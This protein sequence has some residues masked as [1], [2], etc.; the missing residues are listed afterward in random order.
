M[1]A[2]FLTT[3]ADVLDRMQAFVKSRPLAQSVDQTTIRAAVEAGLREIVAARDWN[4]MQR[5]SRIKL[6]AAQ[7]TGTVTYT[8]SAGVYPYQVTLSGATWPDWAATAQIRIGSTISEV[9]AVKSATVLTLRPPRVP[10]ADIATASAYT[11]GREWYELPP[12][13][14]ASWSPAERNAWFI[15]QY[16]PFEDWYLVN[17]YR[18]MTGTV[19]RWTI[20]P[21]P[22]MY[23]AMALYVYPWSAQTVEENLLLKVRPRTLA[24]SGKDAYC[25][26]G[27]ASVTSGGTAV[28]GSGSSF[29]S[30]MVGAVI[31]FS[32]TSTLPTGTAGS[33]PYVFQT[34]I[35]AVTDTTHLT[36]STAAP[37]TFSAV[38]YVVSDPVDLSQPI[39]DAFLRNCEKQLAYAAGMKDAGAVE[40]YYQLALQAAK[41][42]DNAVR[43]KMLVGRPLQVRHRLRDYADRPVLN[44]GN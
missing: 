18:A 17:N 13:F 31:R 22:D 16:T 25:F 44:P 1:S 3:Y 42:A 28:T 6:N 20:G 36:L 33:N 30:S 5:V 11:L 10:V 9:D 41:M 32:D 34:T 39:Y 8:E 38:K 12:E 2:P 23:G 40:R 27:T 35:A 43:Q 21:I 7:T 26:A 19:R 24:I 4:C 37:Q 29:R 15:G 14:V